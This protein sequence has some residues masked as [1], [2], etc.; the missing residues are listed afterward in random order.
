MDKPISRDQLYDSEQAARV[1]ARITDHYLPFYES[2]SDLVPEATRQELFI[3]CG[4]VNGNIELG[5]KLLL[6]A[7]NT[8]GR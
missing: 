1:R 6:D 2:L 5:R 3:Y 4:K 7:G 8:N